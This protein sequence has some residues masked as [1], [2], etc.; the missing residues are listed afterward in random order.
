MPLAGLHCPILL[1]EGEFKMT[2][3]LTTLNLEPFMRNAIGVG[4]LMNSLSERVAH[5]NNGNYPPY[6]IIAL[7]DDIFLVEMA[8]AG[9]A[10]EEISITVEDG[11]LNIAGCHEPQIDENDEEA[12]LTYLH[13][14]IS[15]R[16]FERSFALT[17]HLEVK[18][19]S[20]INGILQIKLE[21]DVPEA[22]KP[23]TIEIK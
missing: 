8:V 23:K 1:Y 4:E 15:A 12:E 18:G 6:N 3:H 20:M 5:L 16:S 17:D 7:K 21:R 9:F 2:R 13:K 11:N 10:Q 19:A 22:L 14:G